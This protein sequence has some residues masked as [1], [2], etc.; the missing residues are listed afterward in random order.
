MGSF[1]DNFTFLVDAKAK[2]TIIPFRKTF[3]KLC[4]FSEATFSKTKI[5]PT[6][7]HKD[8]ITDALKSFQSAIGL[9]VP[10]EGKLGT[11]TFLGSTKRYWFK[12]S[13]HATRRPMGRGTVPY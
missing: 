11:G 8:C 5:M 9:P 7:Q 3:I 1:G 6:R 2:V 13:K 10:T 12:S 4:I